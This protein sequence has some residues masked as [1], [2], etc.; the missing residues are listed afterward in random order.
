MGISPPPGTPPVALLATKVSLSPL[1]VMAIHEEQLRGRS[2]RA[3]LRYV[4]SFAF[5]YCGLPAH[6]PAKSGKVSV[7]GIFNCQGSA[8]P[9]YLIG[10]EKVLRML[11]IVTSSSPESVSDSFSSKDVCLEVIYF[12]PSR[13]PS[14]I[15]TPP[16]PPCMVVIG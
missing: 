10:L 7:E 9:F 11:C 3:K 15:F 8:C 16:P 12:I 1:S 6:H 2:Q 5:G 13:Y 4:R 14:A